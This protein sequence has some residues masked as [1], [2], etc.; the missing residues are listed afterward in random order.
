MLSGQE[1][2]VVYTKTIVDSA[3]TQRK[4]PSLVRKEA[5]KTKASTVGDKQKVQYS[6][7]QRFRAVDT[8]IAKDGSLSDGAKDATEVLKEMG[9]QQ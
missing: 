2:P 9:E 7:T 3:V 6:N 5:V 4:S 8:Q 1:E